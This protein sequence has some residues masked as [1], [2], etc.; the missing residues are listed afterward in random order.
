VVKSKTILKGF[1]Y[2]INLYIAAIKYFKEE[3]VF[4]QLEVGKTVEGKIEKITKF[5]AFVD[6]GE[7]KVGLVHISEVAPTFVREIEDYVQKGQTVKVK[8]LNLSENGKIGLSIKQTLNDGQEH[9]QNRNKI[10]KIRK[11]NDNNLK[12]ASGGKNSFECLMS[13][14]KI[15]SD[16][17]QNLLNK[18]DLGRNGRP[19]R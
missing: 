9:G 7:N 16:E 12:A 8:I 3:V 2:I 13:K 11:V 15:D 4:M 1:Y 17:T 14:F 19:R 6:L 10:R 18:R 5:G